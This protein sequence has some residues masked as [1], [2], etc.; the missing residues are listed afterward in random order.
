MEDL[1]P[2]IAEA[3]K[4]NGSVSFTVSGISMQPMLYHKRDSVTL[5]PP[6]KKLKKYDLPF[7][8][9]DD[10]SFVLHR[11]IKVYKDGTYKCRGDNRWEI[12]DHIRHEQ[13][14]GIVKTFIR[15]GKI[16]DVNESIGYYIYTRFWKFLHPLK[17]Y[18]KFFK[19]F[20]KLENKTRFDYEKMC[21]K[22]KTIICNNKALDVF[23]RYAEYKHLKDIQTLSISFAEFESLNFDSDINLYWAR[24]QS[25]K[26]Y[27]SNLLDNGY[28]F[29]VAIIED[30]VIGYIIGK[31]NQMN[32][33][34]SPCAKLHSIYVLP[35]YQKCGIGS[36]LMDIFKEYCCKNGCYKMNVTFFEKNISAEKFYKKHGF[37]NKSKIYTCDISDS[38]SN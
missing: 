37:Y 2:L 32:S 6:P 21:P 8:Q 24:S 36:D 9:M 34:N 26:K 33:L 13:I 29:W 25:A 3:L 30:T 1:Y 19:I 16:F 20:K 5:V 28:F 31:I 18:Y 38:N 22:K 7:F 15:K 12:E 4:K 17:K 11:V 23:Y 14:I 35:K 27:F 10:G